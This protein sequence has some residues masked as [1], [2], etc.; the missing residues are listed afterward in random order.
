MSNSN[1]AV[2]KVETEDGKKQAE[3]RVEVKETNA[4]LEKISI[5]DDIQV[6]K[7]LQSQGLIDDIFEI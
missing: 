2:I 1:S 4:E 6:K 5:D 7:L 3:C